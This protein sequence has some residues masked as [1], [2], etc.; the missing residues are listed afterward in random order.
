MHILACTYYTDYSGFGTG[1]SLNAV[2]VALQAAI[3]P[4]DKA[5]AASGLYLSMPVGS[6][7]GMA[8][9]NTVMQAIMPVE[10]ASRLR[11][12]GIDGTE[13]DQVT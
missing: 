12:L 3:N 2:F 10:L 5:V 6:I 8:A 4:K 11:S 9:G 1:M 13:A 7:L